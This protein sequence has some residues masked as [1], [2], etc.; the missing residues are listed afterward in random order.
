MSLKETIVDL[1]FAA[2]WALPA[3]GHTEDEAKA[4]WYG[5][6][7]NSPAWN[8]MRNAIIRGARKLRTRPT[9][10]DETQVKAIINQARVT[11]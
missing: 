4:Y 3:P 11:V 5:V 2:G 10:L 1:A 9:A 8:D 6:D 7:P